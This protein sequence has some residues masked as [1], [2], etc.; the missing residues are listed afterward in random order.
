MIIEQE[1]H[2]RVLSFEKAR[3]TG[4]DSMGRSS[5]LLQD[6]LLNLEGIHLCI[7]QMFFIYLTYMSVLIMK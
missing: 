7:A 1:M 4:C 5:F 6:E 3:D 2:A